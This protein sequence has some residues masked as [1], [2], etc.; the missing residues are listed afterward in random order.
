[1]LYACSTVAAF[2]VLQGLL[3]S[4]YKAWA[5]IDSPYRPILSLLPN[6]APVFMVSPNAERYL[7]KKQYLALNYV[8]GNWSPGEIWAGFYSIAFVRHY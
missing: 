3:P 5:L 4:A 1:M 6:H 2:T 8:T 7:E